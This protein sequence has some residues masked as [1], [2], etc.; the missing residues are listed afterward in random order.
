MP[1]ESHDSSDDHVAVV[2]LACRFPGAHDPVEYWRN[3]VGSHEALTW[4]S[5]DDLLASGVSA[6]EFRHPDYVRSAFLMDDMES[7]DAA[8][9]GD[10]PREAQVRDPQIRWFLET[11]YAAV[12][13]SGHDPARLT[14]LVSVVGGMSNNLYGERYV[15]KSSALRNSVGDMAISVGTNSD[16]LATTVAY[17]LG[18]RGPSF[19]VQTACSSSLVAVH[20]ASQML[21][22]GECDYALAGGV[23]I[24]LPHRSG[25][26]WVDGSIFTRDGHIRPFDTGATG[27]MFS[28][29]VGVV[30]LRR[31]ADALESDDHIYAVLRGSA[32]NNDGGDRAGF[33]APGVEGQAQL[34]VE[35]LATA[36]VHPDTIGYV[37][38][39]ATGTLVGDPIEVAGLDRAFRAAGATGRGRVPVGSVKGNVGH[40]GPASGVAGLMKTVL[41]LQN[42]LIPPTINVEEPNPRLN[43]ETSPFHVADRLEPWQTP[44]GTPRRAGVSSFGIGGTNAHVILEQAPPPRVAAPSRR[45]HHVLPVSARTSTAADAAAHRL[46]TF[47]EQNE[48]I[49]LAAVAHTL[50]SGRATFA[51]RRAVVA[52]DRLRAAKLLTAAESGWS[53]GEAT[54]PRIAMIFPGQ[55]TQHPGMG[56]GLLE[57]DPVFRATMLEC[58]RLLEPELGTSLLDVIHPTDPTSA[59]A[60]ARLARTE[61]CQPAL[62]SVEFAL[63]R[64]LRDAGLEPDGML[65]HSI[66]EYVA[67]TLAGVL[68]LEDALR[69]VAT[70]GRLMQAMAPGAMLAV[71]AD[72]E[73]LRGILP[74]GVEVA[75]VNSATTTVV[76]GTTAD[77][78]E[79]ERVLT[80]HGVG[81][82]RLRTSHAFHSGMME[83]AL[84]NF[85]EVVASVTLSEPTRRFVSNVTGTWITPAEATDVE[86]WVRHLREPV[87][88]GP[89]LET[90]AADVGTTVVEVGP[91]SGLAALVASHVGSGRT[92]SCMRQPRQEREDDDVLAEAMAKLWCH[93]ADVDWAARDVPQP[94]V[95]LPTYP[96]ERERLWAEPDR[97]LPR[98]SPDEETVPLPRERCTFAPVWNE[99]PTPDPIGDGSGRTFLVLGATHPVVTALEGRLRGTGARVVSVV[100]GESL[101]RTGPDAF[102]VRAGS[103]DDLDGVLD[104]LA[105]LEVTDVV[106]AWSVTEPAENPIATE[107][108]HATVDTAFYDLL[109]VGQVAARRA[110][111]NVRFV[112]LSSNMQEATGTERVEPAKATL[113]GP[114]ILLEQE[115]P[116]VRSRSVD[117]DL[118]SSLPLGAVADHLLV[119]LFQTDPAPQVAWRGRKRWVQGYAT[120]EMSSVAT[121]DL[122]GGHHLITGG[123]GALGLWTAETLAAA[124]AEGLALLSR[125]EFPPRD[126]WEAVAAD[127]TSRWARTARRLLDIEALGTR[128]VTV[129]CDVAD[130]GEVAA[131]VEH[132]RSELGPIRGVFHSAGVAGGGMLAV[133]SD[134]E[135]ATVLAPKVDGTL[136][137]HRELGDDAEFM[138]LYSSLTAAIGSFGQVDYCAANNFMDSFARWA[139]Q[140][141]H[142]V[143][144]IGWTQWAEAGMAAAD[145]P[146]AP[147][148]FREL[149]TGARYQAV[150]HPLIDHRVL[151]AADGAEFS[152]VLH[153]G[154]HF[155]W[156]EH[157]LD[158]VDVVV[159]TALIEIASAA[160]TELTGVD[161]DVEDVVFIGPIGVVEPTELRVRLSEP[162]HDGVSDAILSVGPAGG[163]PAL[164][165]E[166]MRCRIRPAGRREAVV[167]DLAELKRRCPTPSAPADQLFSD[168]SLIEFG[169]H[170]DDAVRH[171]QLGDREILSLVQLPREFVAEAG[172]YRLHP[173]LLDVA[174]SG[175][176][177]N[178]ARIESGDSYLPFGYGR[179]SAREPLPPTFWVHT[180]R[181]SADGAELDQVDVVVMHTDGTE[182]ATISGYTERRVD[183]EAMR[184]ETATPGGR[185]GT[186]TDETADDGEHIR[187]ELGCDIL[188]R[189]LG[190][191]PAP[192]V[193][194]VPEGI[195][196]SMR[197]SRALTLEVIERE[198]GTASLAGSAGGE[199]REREGFLAPGT[200]EE[201]SIAELWSSALGV[202]AVGVE[203]NFFDLGGNSLVAVQLAARI[204]EALQVELPIATLFDHPT[205]RQLAELVGR[206]RRG[207]S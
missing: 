170:W 196:R 189:V 85:R 119:E 155:A 1:H 20:V 145:G 81:S 70:R 92:V 165:R 171:T 88:F 117:I 184:S 159:G 152:T 25:H 79:A 130:G 83:P 60:A 93:G 168:G 110:L 188:R 175:N 122:A 203:D 149:Q 47:L 61:Y 164:R 135:A 140:R 31:L 52:D 178:A 125:S 50:G 59:D 43:L 29:G 112:V 160:F 18:F 53:T 19:T 77:V 150:G 36:E 121:P 64:T 13:D 91:S 133:R 109:H 158:G 206:Q 181:L 148:A 34:I 123:L 126:T 186:T 3:L 67:A 7:F 187:P 98:A 197:R 166:R 57:H 199:E 35:A 124:G 107:T 90:L 169:R 120:V 11:C 180:R 44:D 65:G 144:S 39:H 162:D 192:H 33:T 28:S 115:V 55:G 200:P 17:R 198:L 177:Y 101:T 21:R 176:F 96:F 141:G 163:A 179:V 10:N 38:A 24:E 172:E 161:G 48:E 45:R 8:F 108:V 94:R 42:G 41:A 147:H 75:A 71:H 104:A 68:D 69:L 54:R 207:A 204:R 111:T 154:G 183:G 114:S 58:S 2:G 105:P 5:D 51:H 134:A 194:V 12:E 132:V 73:A 113:L 32:V 62:F 146:T 14:G 195:H 103:A 30:A 66:G 106:H 138:V 118:P 63:A 151:S 84:A 99:A 46:G 49:S 74:R 78:E 128:V 173:V 182:V 202:G 185:H 193:L 102:T 139:T 143:F 6:A 131:A 26:R 174:A 129:R 4:L 153:P 116:G 56:A 76:A 201:E 89:G 37:E 87:L 16:Y 23:E 40:L 27:T 127:L 190:W 100:G 80:G 156:A 205:I 22:A 15:E 136:A 137:L 95:P 86:Y 97:E 82:T 142:Q 157:R 9:F 191:R 167:H 72:V